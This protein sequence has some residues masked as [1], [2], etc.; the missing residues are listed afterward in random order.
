[1]LFA[2]ETFLHYNDMR[3][4]DDDDNNNDVHNDK[5]VDVDEE[6]GDEEVDNDD[7]DKRVGTK[8]VDDDGN[9]EREDNTD[10][11]S[12]LWAFQWGH[13]VQCP[14]GWKLDIDNCESQML[15][16]IL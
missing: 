5:S 3:V 1:M 15:Q 6:E 2:T 16:M 12:D 8:G 14:W 9:N 11:T 10:I 4:D 7:N 13:R